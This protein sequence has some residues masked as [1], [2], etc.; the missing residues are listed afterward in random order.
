MKAA[1]LRD[2]I[3]ETLRITHTASHITTKPNVKITTRLFITTAACFT[4]FAG[5]DVQ[6]CDVR[7]DDR[8][9]SES[10]G[11][12]LCMYCTQQTGGAMLQHQLAHLTTCYFIH[13]LL[14]GL[15]LLSIQCGRL[16][17]PYFSRPHKTVYFYYFNTS[18]KDKRSALFWDITQRIAVIYYRRFGTNSR[19]L[20]LRSRNF[21]EIILDFL[22]MGPMGF[23]ETPVRNY[24]YTLRNIPEERKSHIRRGGSL[25]PRK[26]KILFYPKTKLWAGIVQSV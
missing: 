17:V 23:P 4:F 18:V 12:S 6:C 26:L 25:K 14:H 11:Q 16:R 22:K 21:Q 7:S 15:Q 2:A 8:L 24:Y 1:V 13:P 9:D 10:C 20:L 5:S 19:S 3:K